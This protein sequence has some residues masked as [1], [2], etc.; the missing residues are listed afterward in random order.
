MADPTLLAD[1]VTLVRDIGVPAAALF[2]CLWRLDKRLETLSNQTQRLLDLHT[3]TNRLLNG[4][5]LT[6]PDTVHN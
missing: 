4:H 3:Q 1:V 2:Y 6:A 5:P